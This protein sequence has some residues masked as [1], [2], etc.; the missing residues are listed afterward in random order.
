MKGKEVAVKVL[1]KHI[2]TALE[3][4]KNNTHNTLNCPVA[5]AIADALKVKQAGCGYTHANAGNKR[6]DLP[7]KA[8]SFIAAFDSGKRKLRSISFTM[9]SA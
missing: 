1:Q 7:Q 2:K 9:T 6:F 4:K 8:T 3:H 5:L